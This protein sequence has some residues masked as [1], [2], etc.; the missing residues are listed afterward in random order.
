MG[1]LNKIGEAASS[2]S[3]NVNEK[4]KNMSDT[5][6]LK[7]KILYEEER[8][9]EI[10]TDIGKTYYKTPDKVDEL[11]AYCDDI[12]TRKKRIKKMRKAS[13]R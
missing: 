4:T 13:K 10:F 12:E 3:R 7:R 1:I 5:S 11:K 8:I 6:N 2:A 9:V